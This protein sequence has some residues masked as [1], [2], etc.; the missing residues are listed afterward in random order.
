[1]EGFASSIR[2]TVRTVR[3]TGYRILYY[4][5]LLGDKFYG[6]QDLPEP[7]SRA[8][9]TDACALSPHQMAIL[10]DVM[11]PI[12]EN[13]PEKCRS[14]FL[15]PIVSALF[16]Q[17]DRKASS[18]WERIE[19]RTR[20]AGEGD[21]LAKEMK[22][23]SVLRQLTMASVMCVVG[24]LEPPKPSESCLRS[25]LRQGPK[26]PDPSAA[27]GG[28]VNGSTSHEA[29]TSLRDF[30]LQTPNILKPI[31][32]FCMHALRMRD[33]RSCSLIAKVLRT[34]VNEFTGDGAVERDV[35]EFISTEVLKA[36]ITS[37]NDPYFVELQRDF[38]Q[39]IASILV[40]YGPRTETPKQVLQSLPGMETERLDRAVR[41]LFRA[42]SNSRQQR[43]IVLELLQ[44]FRGIA[45]HEQGRL[46]K[47]DP[48]KLRSAMQQKYM[49]ADSENQ[50]V[51]QQDSPDVPDLEGLADMFG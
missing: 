41:Q 47:Q 19:E 35:R 5:S 11:R 22:D 14:Q 6:F 33:T 45:I 13:C 44:G 38:A 26:S 39:L 50:Y 28:E 51:K 25:S 10:V 15:P 46:P 32:L 4:M 12:I 17:V 27:P 2:A 16:E 43:A 49:T 21:D 48:K 24:L 18:E 37:L 34:L 8:L 23:E 29:S 9:F 3:E 31:V 42:Q 36:C 1:M 20:A 40:T 30:I 7:L